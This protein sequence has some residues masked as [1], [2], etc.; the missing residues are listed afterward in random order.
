MMSAVMD[1]TEWTVAM[2]TKIVRLR[3]VARKASD[4]EARE[5]LHDIARELHAEI[6]FI[7]RKYAS[8]SAG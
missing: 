1:H 4:E 2:R 6:D 8:P 3:L 7:E 5:A